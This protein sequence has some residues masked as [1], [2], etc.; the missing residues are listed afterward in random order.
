MS[1]YQYMVSVY[2]SCLPQLNRSLRSSSVTRMSP[3]REPAPSARFQRAATVGPTDY[4]SAMPFTYQYNLASERYNE[5]RNRLSSLEPVRT[6]SRA[7]STSG[8]SSRDYKVMDYASRLDQE[9][10]TREYI[11]SRQSRLDRHLSRSATPHRS[12]GSYDFLSGSRNRYQ[13]D[14]TSPFTE[15]YNK[16]DTM[17]FER[18]YMY[19]TYDVGASYKHFRLSNQ[20]L[21]LRNARAK[22]PVQSRELD[23]YYKTERRTSFIGDVSNGADFRYYSYRPVPYFGGSDN[24]QM[25]KRRQRR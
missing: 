2:R 1:Y 9:E 10:T 4:A 14:S 21:N 11:S 3:E 22:S 20:T 15:R 17:K 16:Y 7:F 25:T 23:R 6:Y 5:T 8:Y 18:D 24:Y 12:A 13:R 19:D